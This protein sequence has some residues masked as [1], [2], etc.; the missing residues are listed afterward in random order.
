[1][2]ASY[3]TSVGQARSAASY[4]AAMEMKKVTISMTATMFDDLRDRARRRGV[5]VT[6]LMRRA[7]VVEKLLFDD[8]ETEVV[9]RRQG[10]E[11]LLRL[12]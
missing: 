5:T 8:P 10:R 3:R 12:I 6:E 11:E 9:L 2:R 1:M 7:V 4:Y